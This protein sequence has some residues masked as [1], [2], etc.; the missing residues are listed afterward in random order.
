MVS[1]QEYFTTPTEDLSPKQLDSFYSK[2]EESL[3]KTESLT[4]IWQ[5]TS[6]QI[7]Q[8]ETSSK[9]CED[10]TKLIFLIDQRINHFFR[11][12]YR[13]VISLNTRNTFDF[14]C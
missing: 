6:V 1:N 13:F 3:Y 9:S 8:P 10:W 5:F 7:F 14:S 11:C 2:R 12:V 4:A